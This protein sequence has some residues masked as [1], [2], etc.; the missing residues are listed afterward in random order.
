MMVTYIS[1]LCLL[2]V[3]L[4]FPDEIVF[5]LDTSPTKE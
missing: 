5:V 4:P 2:L 3:P 1:F